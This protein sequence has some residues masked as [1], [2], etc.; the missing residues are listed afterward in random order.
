LSPSPYEVSKERGKKLKEGLT[1][2]L[3]AL[4]LYTGFTSLSLGG[5]WGKDYGLTRGC[6]EGVS[7]SMEGRHG[8][9]KIAKW[10]G[11]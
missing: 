8:W 10:G 9:E 7:P 4:Q 5:W 2:L 3:N 6:C 11:G 1:P